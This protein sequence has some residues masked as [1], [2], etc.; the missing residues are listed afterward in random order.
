MRDREEDALDM[1]VGILRELRTNVDAEGRIQLSFDALV[2][3]D[4]LLR[5]LKK[6]IPSPELA[7]YVESLLRDDVPVALTERIP[8]LL[9]EREEK[10]NE[11]GL[12]G[13]VAGLEWA[14]GLAMEWAVEAFKE[15]RD[16]E[17]QGYRRLAQELRDEGEQIG[18]EGAVE[19]EEPAF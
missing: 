1:A 19:D 6:P 14:S 2:G 15:G 12:A 16:G 17:A 8:K 7:L 4:R 10:L 11:V 18:R 3:S 9:S 5:Y 13:R